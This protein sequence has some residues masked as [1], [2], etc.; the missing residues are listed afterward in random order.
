MKVKRLYNTYNLF[1]AIST[2]ATGYIF[3]DI[4]YEN[5][6][7]TIDLVNEG[8]LVLSRHVVKLVVGALK[9]LYERRHRAEP[10]YISLLT[11]QEKT[12]LRLIAQDATNKKVATTLHISENTVKVHVRNILAKLQAR[13]RLE[14]SISAIEEGLV[15]KYNVHGADIKQV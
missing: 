1:S 15:Y 9:F 2:G 3:K 10:S 6:L 4:S 11:E 8:Q 7:K 5:L 12:I 14:A 13:N